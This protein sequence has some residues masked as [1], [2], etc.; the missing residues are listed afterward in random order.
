MAFALPESTEENPK[1]FQFILKVIWT[2]VGATPLW[3]SQGNLANFLCQ[4]DSLL[5][6]GGSW[7][8]SSWLWR[9]N[10]PWTCEP[11]PERR[12]ARTQ[13]RNAFLHGNIF[14]VTG[15]KVV[16]IMDSCIQTT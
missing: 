7:S 9:L 12:S 5:H 13:S 15:A 2:A 10:A 16:T 4:V 6:L 8:A 11:H 3:I 14:C 1:N